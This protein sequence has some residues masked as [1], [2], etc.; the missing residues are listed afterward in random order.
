[1]FEPENPA[2]GHRGSDVGNWV[3][4]CVTGLARDLELILIQQSLL[5]G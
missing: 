4:A 5:S 2:C 1:M 3:L